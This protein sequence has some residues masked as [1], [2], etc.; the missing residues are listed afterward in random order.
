MVLQF[1]S[2]AFLSTALAFTLEL[3][4]IV[5]LLI[6]ALVI[7]LA[8]PGAL[9][10]IQTLSQRMQDPAWLQNPTELIS[11]ARHPA[12]IILAL[13]VFAVAVPLIEEAVKAIGV[14]LMG[15]R[16][17]SLPQAVLWGLAGGAGF[18]FAEGLLNS[19]SGLD[20][21]PLSVS[22]RTGATLLH[23]FTGALMGLAWYNILA[24]RRWGRG[25]ALYGAS[26]AAHGLWNA[27]AGGMALLSLN[28][29]AGASSSADE[30]WIGPMTN[31][32]MALLLCLAGA[33]AIGLAGLTR[34]SRN[35]GQ[36]MAAAEELQNAEGSEPAMIESNPPEI[37]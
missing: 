26:V 36:E 11:L 30:A 9:E 25:L 31:L 28:E 17:P 37:P 19:I 21:W 7:V 4:L 13:L 8:S 35:E 34:Y 23:C 5:V 3:V 29:L 27:L 6:A 18:A 24:Q 32:L 20:F 14:G 2:G 22:V 12:V 16:H 33:V 1:S 15:Y 10:Q